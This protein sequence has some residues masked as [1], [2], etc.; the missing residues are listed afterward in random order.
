MKLQP[1]VEDYV[2][3]EDFGGLAGDLY[4]TDENGVL[5]DKICYTGVNHILTLRAQDD[6]IGTTH[7]PRWATIVSDIQQGLEEQ[8][9]KLMVWPC[10]DE[11]Y[12]VTFQ[13]YVRIRELSD[14]NPKPPGG[15]DHA[16]LFRAAI[17]AAI[18]LDLEDQHGPQ[19]QNFMQQ[20]QASVSRDRA[21]N[22]PSSLGYN[23]DGPSMGAG[24]YTRVP[25]PIRYSSE[26]F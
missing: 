2:L 21:L 18:E 22:M 23:G 20:L 6:F 14:S 11:A 16:A 9:S 7:H 10:P 5:A 17:L 25:N 1:G 12:S 13:Y 19:Y 8:R 15:D 4:F 24:P 26:D 3:G